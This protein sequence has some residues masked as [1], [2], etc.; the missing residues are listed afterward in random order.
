MIGVQ[1]VEQPSG[2][3]LHLGQGLALRRT[4]HTHARPSLIAGH[5]RHGRIGKIALR[6]G[7]ACSGHDQRRNQKKTH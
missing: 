6:Q 4:H 2:P 3:R 7:G 5:L 1:T